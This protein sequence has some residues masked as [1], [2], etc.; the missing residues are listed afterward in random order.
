MLKHQVI[1]MTLYLISS[2]FLFPFQAGLYLVNF[3]KIMCNQLMNVKKPIY[4]LYEENYFS[5]VY[6]TIQELGIQNLHF[7]SHFIFKSSVIFP[8][9]CSLNVCIPNS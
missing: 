6:K 3:E 1:S 8:G 7:F 5:N 4:L 9:L 2:D